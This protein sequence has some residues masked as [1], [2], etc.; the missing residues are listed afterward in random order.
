[1]TKFFVYLEKSQIYRLEVIANNKEQARN[2]ALENPDNF[3]SKKMD[4]SWHIHP[5]VETS[6]ESDARNNCGNP[7]LKDI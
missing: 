6:A 5:Y 3:I 2:L 1:M 4:S 7:F